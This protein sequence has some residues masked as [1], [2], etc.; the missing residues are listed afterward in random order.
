MSDMA[1]W[2][3][4]IDSEALRR[5]HIIDDLLGAV[6]LLAAAAFVV[7]LE[8]TRRQVCAVYQLAFALCAS[9]A[10]FLVGGLVD[11]H[12]SDDQLSRAL[13]GSY[14]SS[15]QYTYI[16]IAAS[17]LVSLA[18][19][20]QLSSCDGC[21]CCCVAANSSASTSTV[22]HKQCFEGR[23]RSQ[24]SLYISSC[25]TLFVAIGT[26]LNVRLRG[27]AINPIG[28]TVHWTMLRSPCFLS[29]IHTSALVLI[30][31]KLFLQHVR[32][33]ADVVM[34]LCRSTLE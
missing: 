10:F 14:L 5:V 12:V 16:P 29:V 13:Y 15:T 7:A 19:V 21:E 22:S 25:V 32:H 8:L 33:C 17:T 9:W 18:L 20:L 11:H 27:S 23:I 6:L 28:G 31:L 24:A 1:T 26:R 30:A 2:D 4:G 3:T 34:S